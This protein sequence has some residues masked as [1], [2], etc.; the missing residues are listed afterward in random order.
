MAETKRGG[1]GRGQ[2]RKPL[3]H[4]QATVVITLRMTPAQRERLRLL[5]GPKWV[6]KQID[7]AAKSAGH[8]TSD[9]AP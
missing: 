3:S 9:T 2:G 6:R 5:G 8:F 7:A 1:P 4:D